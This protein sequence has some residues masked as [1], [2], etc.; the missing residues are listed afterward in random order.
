MLILILTLSLRIPPLYVSTLYYR[1][2]IR[3]HLSHRKITATL[4]EQGGGIKTKIDEVVFAMEA[5]LKKWGSLLPLSIGLQQAVLE[6][7][8]TW[9]HV[10]PEAEHAK[11]IGSYWYTVR[12]K[13]VNLVKET[14]SKQQD[15]IALGRKA[16]KDLIDDDGILHQMCSIHE[17]VV[18]AIETEALCRRSLRRPESLLEAASS[19]ISVLIEQ[20]QRCLGNTT[21]KLKAGQMTCLRQDIRFTESIECGLKA[22]MES[23]E[24]RKRQSKKEKDK[25]IDKGIDKGKGEVG[26][27]PDKTC[28]SPPVKKKAAPSLLSLYYDSKCLSKRLEGI[29]RVYSDMIEAMC[30]TL[31]WCLEEAVSS[32]FQDKI[33]QYKGRIQDTCVSTGSLCDGEVE[34]LEVC[35][36]L[37]DVVSSK[38]KGLE[39]AEGSM[40]RIQKQMQRVMQAHVYV[41][42][43]PLIQEFIETGHGLVREIDLTGFSAKAATAMFAV[44]PII[45]AIGYPIRSR[46]AWR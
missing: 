30:E 33:E 22:W 27:G 44:K 41:E 42:A 21:L 11:W 4:D 26:K 12:R 35:R 2:W 32:N 13:T 3:H 16:P 40:E 10:T 9:S 28:K 19:L 14:F 7:K 29:D 1:S 23:K 6:A 36:L 25:G 24:N 20:L 5:D 39:S 46:I 17:S 38:N 15:D 8:E 18:E 37:E 31:S 34:H 45:Q 43:M